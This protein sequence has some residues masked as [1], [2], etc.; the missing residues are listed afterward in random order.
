MRKQFGYKE[1]K[2]WPAT[3]GMNKKGGMADVKFERYVE[4]LTRPLFPNLEGKTGQSMLLKRDSGPGWNCKELLAKC[5]FSG[6]YIYPGLPNTTAVQQE[7]DQ[8]YGP[9]KSV[10]QDT[11]ESKGYPSCLLC[12]RENNIAGDVFVWAHHVRRSLPNLETCLLKCH[13]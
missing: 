5:K 3:M 2:I 4:N 1:E 12:K 10:V 13:E 6:V 9:F 7:T 11:G 8:N